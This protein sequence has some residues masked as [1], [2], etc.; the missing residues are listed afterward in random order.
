M[1]SFTNR[2]V[3]PSHAACINNCGKKSE[4][5][6]SHLEEKKNKNPVLCFKMHSFSLLVAQLKQQKHICLGM[7]RNNVSL[8]AGVYCCRFVVVVAVVVV[9]KVKCRLIGSI[10]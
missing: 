1:V 8:E 9:S 10:D 7:K 4:K 6:C 5:C 2:S 3:A